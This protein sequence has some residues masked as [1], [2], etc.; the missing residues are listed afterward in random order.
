MLNELV[1]PISHGQGEKH[2]HSG[3]I[4]MVMWLFETWNALVGSIIYGQG[5]SIFTQGGYSW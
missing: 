3:W 4:L 5:K 1:A 2:L